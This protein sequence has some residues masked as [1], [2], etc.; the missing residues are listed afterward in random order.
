MSQTELVKLTGTI[1]KLHDHHRYYDG[2]KWCE[3]V[4]FTFVDQERRLLLIRYCFGGDHDAKIFEQSLCEGMRADILV[5][6]PITPEENTYP[7]VGSITL[8]EQ[9]EQK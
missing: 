8:H 3:A 9:R 4:L 5:R 2:K 6:G 1:K 7:G